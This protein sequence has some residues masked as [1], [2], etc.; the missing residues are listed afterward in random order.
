MSD[1][2]PTESRRGMTREITGFILEEFNFDSFERS[3]RLAEGV[4]Q[5]DIS[6]YYENGILRLVFKEVE[7]AEKESSR[8]IPIK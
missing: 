4:G 6:A 8:E 1:R 7:V 3:F 2:K 5:D